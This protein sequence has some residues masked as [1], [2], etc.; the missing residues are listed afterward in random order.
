MLK[1]VNDACNDNGFFS[2][3]ARTV[4]TKDGMNICQLWLHEM[5]CQE[6]Q[7]ALH[8]IASFAFHRLSL[9]ILLCQQLSCLASEL[10]E[11]CRAMNAVLTKSDETEPDS[12]VLNR[13]FYIE[14]SCFPV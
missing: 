6:T 13:Q 9:K 3:W 2:L 12:R 5:G 7:R 4:F 11:G 14:N 10:K 1:D 8:A